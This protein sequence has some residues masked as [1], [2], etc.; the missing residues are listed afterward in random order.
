MRISEDT[1]KVL[2]YS[3]LIADDRHTSLIRDTIIFAA[4]CITDSPAK[5]TIEENVS[6]VNAILE[7]LGISGDYELD[8]ESVKALADKA[9]SNLRI[10]VRRVFA[11]AAELSRRTGGR[12]AVGPEH[13]LFVILSRKVSN[14]VDI[15]EALEYAGA[16][17]EGL[18]NSL[19][20]TFN[21]NRG[22]QC[23]GH[24]NN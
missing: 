11:N 19:V 17:F 3:Q 22:V 2:A 23:F 18:R 4:I 10:D 9:F 15:F 6:N 12:G 8:D 1:A 20:N 5:E 7:K 16:D 24:I 13:I 21:D 14:H